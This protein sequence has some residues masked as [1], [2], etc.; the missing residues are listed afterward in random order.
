MEFLMKS[1]RK[2]SYQKCEK[3]K[4]KENAGGVGKE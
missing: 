1:A 3:R 4:A 2:D